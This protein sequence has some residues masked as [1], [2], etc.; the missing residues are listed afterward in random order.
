MLRGSFMVVL[1]SV[2]STANA[3]VILNRIDA[4]NFPSK[5]AWNLFLLVNHPAKSTS[6]GRGLPDLSKLIGEPGTTV[7]WET[8]RL[9]EKEVFLEDGVEPP[10]WDDTSLPGGDVTGKV[11]DPPKFITVPL[12][13]GASQSRK[14]NLFKL[15][16]GLQPLFD[17]DEGIFEG[18]GGFGESRMNRATYDFILQ[19]GIYSREGLMRY[20][21]AYLKGNKPLLSF[22]VE[23]M[24]VKAAWIELTPEQIA[25]GE[26]RTFYL[27]AWNG[28]TYGLTALHII[29]KDLP[30]WFWCTFHHKSAPE[31]GAETPD[32]YGQPSQLAGT[33]WENYELGGTQIDFINSIGQPTL[34]SD[35]YIE[36]G[37]EQTSCITC[38][39]R[40]TVGPNPNVNPLGSSL[41]V[42]VPNP[43]WFMGSSGDQILM[44]TD[45]L[46][47]LPFRAKPES[48]STA[49][50]SLVAVAETHTVVIRDH[51]YVP[52]VIEI[53]A[54]DSIIWKNEGKHRHTATR[55]ET[56]N[57]FDTGVLQPGDSS[58][59]HLFDGSSFDID[60]S[61]T[62]HPFM[63]GTIRMKDR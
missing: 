57:S 17:P 55:S 25:N 2:A 15:H 26:D 45:F 22:P 28:K 49:T 35:P 27:A 42:G 19:H 51:E 39:S 53:T 47:S 46:W 23:S 40:A 38:H 41:D 44:Q 24:E 36:A 18:V 32:T 13:M 48:K 1:L 50:K 31:T 10:E 63:Q 3:Q 59:P 12:A 52:R 56:P 43:D 61:C 9:S 30:N 5:H 54:G 14:I 11:P 4:A 21:D 33:V 60:Y 58:G 29:T 62:P 34:L 6:D 16:S 7:V 20:A 8:W 37:F